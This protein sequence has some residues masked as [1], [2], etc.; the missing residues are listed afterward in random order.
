[1]YSYNSFHKVLLIFIVIGWAMFHFV[2]KNNEDLVYDNGNPIRTGEVKEH[3]N[4][5]PWTWYFKNGKP[6]I[7]GVFIE[8]KREGEWKIFDS[9]GNILMKSN[10]QKNLLNG[11]QTYYNTDGTIQ[12]VIFYKNDNIVWKK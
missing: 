7:S 9:L 10:Y 8:G 6:Q 12:K 4:D 3:M 11:E 5:G 1:M 2:S